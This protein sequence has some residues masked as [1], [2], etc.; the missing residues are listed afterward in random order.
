[1][2]DV[3]NG[4]NSLASLGKALDWRQICIFTKF[5]TIQMRQN[6]P[7]WRHALKRLL[8]TIMSVCIAL[9]GYAGEGACV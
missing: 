6:V 3:G 4:A 1:M 5:M 8:S 9:N 2:A 7:N